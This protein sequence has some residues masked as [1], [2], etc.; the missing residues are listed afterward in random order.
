MKKTKHK[1]I[2]EINAN[3]IS[4][5]KNDKSPQ[6]WPLSSVHRHFLCEIWS[7]CAENIQNTSNWYVFRQNI[8]MDFLWT[9]L[10]IRVFDCVFFFFASLERTNSLTQLQNDNIFHEYAFP[11]FIWLSFVCFELT[12]VGL[13]I[14]SF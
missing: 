12:F 4:I 8:S 13:K 7:F 11:R 2:S 3:F 1:R 9:E 10:A 5:F 6:M 14:K